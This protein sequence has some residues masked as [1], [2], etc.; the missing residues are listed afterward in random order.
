MACPSDNQLKEHSL[1]LASAVGPF[2]AWLAER[3]WNHAAQQ[4]SWDCLELLSYA[5]RYSPARLEVAVTR[6]MWYRAED[7][8]S[9]RLVFAYDLDQL[10]LRSDGELEGQLELPFKGP[11]AHLIRPPNSSFGSLS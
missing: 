6:M 9:L 7:L 3:L 5:R 4:A 10:C 2:T 11:G 1:A 8:A